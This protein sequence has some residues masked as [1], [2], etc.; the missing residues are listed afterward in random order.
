M[1]PGVLRLLVLGSFRYCKL[2]NTGFDVLREHEKTYHY[3]KGCTVD[4]EKYENQIQGQIFTKNVSNG[5]K[6]TENTLLGSQMLSQYH[7]DEFKFSLAFAS[8]PK[9]TS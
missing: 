6:T 5:R 4:N 1:P 3:Q 8:N 9:R 7:T 2:C